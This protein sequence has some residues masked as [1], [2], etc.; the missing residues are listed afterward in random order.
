MKAQI[1][2]TADQT[3]IEPFLMPPGE[4]AL[5][6][7]SALGADLHEAGALRARTVVFRVRAEWHRE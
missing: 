3:A 5:R 2:C 4:D 6:F 7:G 1:V